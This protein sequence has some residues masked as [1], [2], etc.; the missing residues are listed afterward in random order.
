MRERLLSIAACAVALAGALRLT[1]VHLWKEASLR[2]VTT[3]RPAERFAALASALPI[4]ERL[5]F[6]TAERDPERAGRAYFDA[7][8]ALAPRT[9]AV[10]DGRARRCVVDRG[11]SAAVEPR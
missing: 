2:G 11:A 4:D 3:A 8:F 6:R 10:E 1:S 9:L 5:C 7:L